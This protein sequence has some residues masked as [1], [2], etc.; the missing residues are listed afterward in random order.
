MSRMFSVSDI[1]SL[2]REVKKGKYK[3]DAADLEGYKAYLGKLYYKELLSAE[4]VKAQYDKLQLTFT[5]GDAQKKEELAPRIAL[6]NAAL[7]A[8]QSGGIDID[9]QDKR[10][11]LK[12]VTAVSLVMIRNNPR[13]SGLSA[14]AQVLKLDENVFY[15]F[16]FE[17]IVAA[18][19][20]DNSSS[21][22]YD[23][24]F[25]VELCR[26]FAKNDAAYMS[27]ISNITDLAGAYDATEQYYSRVKAKLSEYR[28][29]ERIK[30]R[31]N[32]ANDDELLNEIETKLFTRMDSCRDLRLK[33]SMLLAVY[34]P[35][36]VAYLCKNRDVKSL[37]K[38]TIEDG[39]SFIR[40]LEGNAKYGMTARIIKSIAPYVNVEIKTDSGE[41]QDHSAEI[42]EIIAQREE[43]KKQA[44]A[45]QRAEDLKILKD[46]LPDFEKVELCESELKKHEY[47]PEKRA[48]GSGTVIKD[49]ILG[50]IAGAGCYFGIIIAIATTAEANEWSD[51]SPVGV[52]FMTMFSI[53]GDDYNGMEK[54]IIF[55]ALI[56]AI[57]GIVIAL[58]RSASGVDKQNKQIEKLHDYVLELKSQ[59]QEQFNIGT[60]KVENILPENMRRA[61]TIKELINILEYNRAESLGDAMNIIYAGKSSY[62]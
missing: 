2:C 29:R 17:E 30:R 24:E 3:G 20:T 8:L 7:E 35:E 53:F 10:S 48:L 32:Q 4:A 49:F 44:A 41:A 14:E 45:S 62:Y 22:T 37:D 27:V 60:R 13:Y 19:G 54:A 42:A 59:R 33:L 38:V 23:A 16:T 5:A 18:C 34:N 25:I 56:F 61:D 51:D 21:I 57:I 46:A 50:G 47:I 52:L 31:Q 43:T 58:K 1:Q 11:E 40:A 36:C 26:L 12:A 6:L 39:A 28:E 55:Y 9:E 15:A